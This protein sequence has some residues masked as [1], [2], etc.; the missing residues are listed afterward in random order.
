MGERDLQFVRLTARERKAVADTAVIM[1]RLRELRDDADD[2][3]T[4][5]IA[6]AAHVCREI[7]D[8]STVPL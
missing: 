3:L 5:D 7:L 2:D 4:T 8:T 1:E 6:L